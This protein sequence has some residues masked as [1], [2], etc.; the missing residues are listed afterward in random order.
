LW[1]AGA[2][3]GVAGLGLA[4]LFLTPDPSGHGT[5][6]QLGLPPCLAMW[7][8][9]LPCPGCGVTT[10]VVLAARG[11]FAAALANQPFGFAVFFGVVAFAGWA[12]VAELTGRNLHADVRLLNRANVWVPVAALLLA[13]WVYKLVTL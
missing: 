12:L 1:L 13:A 4:A 6:C 9:G 7:L 11:D 8:L 5:H 3:A 10:S 2:A